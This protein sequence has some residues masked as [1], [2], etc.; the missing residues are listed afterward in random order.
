[1]WTQPAL[2]FETKDKPVGRDSVLAGAPPPSLL[3]S[4]TEVLQLLGPSGL[5]GKWPPSYRVGDL[6]RALAA[7]ERGVVADAGGLPVFTREQAR[8]VSRLVETFVRALDL[9]DSNLV[10]LSYEEESGKITTVTIGRVQLREGDQSMRLA[11]ADAGKL[12]TAYAYHEPDEWKLTKAY[13]MDTVFDIKQALHLP[14]TSYPSLAPL[15]PA[16]AVLAV[17]RDASGR[18]I[19]F[20]VESLEIDMW[21]RPSISIRW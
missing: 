14:L 17:E 1:M 3:L 15:A 8:L 5:A 21:T 7:L 2:A 4:P 16:V 19:G 11:F 20:R 10:R 6:R 18:Q 9:S 13:A 12:I